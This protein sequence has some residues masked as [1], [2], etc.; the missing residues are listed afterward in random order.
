MVASERAVRDAPPLFIKV[1]KYRQVLEQIE[2]LRS[3]SLSLRDALDAL[4][5]MER[6]VQA[7]LTICHKGLDNLNATL[8]ILHSTISRSNVEEHHIRS[9]TAPIRV[10]TPREIEDYVKGMYQQMEKIKRDLEAIE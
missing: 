8:S 5:E 9:V 2:K 7:G 1:D 6:E 10:E 3:F 4:T